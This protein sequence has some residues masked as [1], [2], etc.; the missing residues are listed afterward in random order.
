MQMG[1]MW[2]VEDGDCDLSSGASNVQRD[3]G[4]AVE[5]LQLKEGGRGEM[6]A[7]GK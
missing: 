7:I 1:D 6:V 2:G 3:A 5:M 4:D